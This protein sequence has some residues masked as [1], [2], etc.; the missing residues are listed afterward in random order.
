MPWRET[1]I[2][3]VEGKVM[4]QPVWLVSEG[5]GVFTADGIVLH[6]VS[7]IEAHI[8]AGEAG[9]YSMFSHL[10][11]HPVI[12]VLGGVTLDPLHIVVCLDGLAPIG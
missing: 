12:A 11:Q 4:S 6:G 8:R 1:V 5:Y 7:H 3:L 10:V 2:P 9:D